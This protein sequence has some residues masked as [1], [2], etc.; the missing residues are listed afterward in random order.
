MQCDRR[1]RSTVAAALAAAAM[2]VGCG[3]GGGAESAATLD[4]P[5]AR[6]AVLDLYLT[7]QEYIEMYYGAG[8]QVGAPDAV[9][10][11]V[12]RSEARFH[13]LMQLLGETPPPSAERV[14][15]A[16]MMVTSTHEE[17]L[18]RARSAGVRLAPAERPIESTPDG[19]LE[20]GITD[21]RDGLAS[22]AD[23]YAPGWRGGS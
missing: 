4:A 15:R 1:W 6:K 5:A 12:D 16:I 20:D 19:G 9:D 18:T 14:S 21:I 11:I 22:I 2:A 10:E 7:R 17:L 23:G 8:G 13:E 3:A